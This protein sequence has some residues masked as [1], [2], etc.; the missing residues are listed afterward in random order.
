M[1]RERTQEEARESRKPSEAARR[2][3][4]KTATEITDGKDGRRK[5]GRRKETRS[6]KECGEETDGKKPAHK[7]RDKKDKAGK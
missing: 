1:I 6:E 4:Q 5:R 2:K 3:A 7:G